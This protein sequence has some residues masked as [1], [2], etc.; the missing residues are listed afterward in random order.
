M[1]CQ[2]GPE[3]HG[4]QDENMSKCAQTGLEM[5]SKQAICQDTHFETPT[6]RPG[7]SSGEAWG[8]EARQLIGGTAD[9]ALDL[10][11]KIT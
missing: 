9:K 1:P 6:H 11:R 5:S 3:M 10:K 7:R 8:V 2:T 4:K